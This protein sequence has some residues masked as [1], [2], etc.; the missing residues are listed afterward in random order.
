MGME[1]RWEVG[2]SIESRYFCLS[3]GLDE[4]QPHVPRGVV[5]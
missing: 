3:L 1:P 2:Y 5:K 4:A